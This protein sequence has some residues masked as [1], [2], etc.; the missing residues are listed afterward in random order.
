MPSRYETRSEMGTLLYDQVSHP[1]P[2]VS[3]QYH[4]GRQ[5]RIAESDSD[6]VE[7]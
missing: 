1:T 4:P 6:G 5:L 2:E 3:M 7:H